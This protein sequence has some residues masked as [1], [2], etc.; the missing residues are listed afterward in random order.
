M[1]TVEQNVDGDTECEGF[2]TMSS[3]IGVFGVA[4]IGETKLIFRESGGAEEL[5]KLL[6]KV[7]GELREAEEELAAERAAK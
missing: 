7:A 6:R 5:S 3:T 2:G 1:V 4:E